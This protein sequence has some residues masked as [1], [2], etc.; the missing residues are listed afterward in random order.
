MSKGRTLAMSGLSHQMHCKVNFMSPKH[1]CVVSLEIRNV[2]Q[3]LHRLTL[4]YT[5]LKLCCDERFKYV[6]TALHCVFIVEIS[7][8]CCF[9]LIEKFLL[10]TQNAAANLTLTNVTTIQ[11]LGQNETMFTLEVYGIIFFV[12]ITLW[13][14]LT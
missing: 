8:R 11:N 9:Q 12:S 10:K 14:I 4:K 2:R 6:S 7:K 13:C 3:L 5:S 1:N